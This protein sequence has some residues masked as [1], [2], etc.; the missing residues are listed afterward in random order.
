MN[1][2]PDENPATVTLPSEPSLRAQRWLLRIAVVILMTGLPGAL[3]PAV[4]FEKLSWL[5]GYGPP[6]LT[7]LTIYLAGNAGYAYVALAVLLWAISRDPRRHQPLVRLTGWI[8]LVAG[9]AYL[10]IDLQCGLP[11]WWVLTDSA[12]CVLLGSLLLRACRPSSPRAMGPK[13]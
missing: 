5:T 12:S 6:P 4:A 8:F 13:G 10:S 3:L 1:P 2:S 11:W 9:P 7:P